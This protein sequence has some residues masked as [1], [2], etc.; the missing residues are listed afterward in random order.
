MSSDGAGSSIGQGNWSEASTTR[1]ALVGDSTLDNVLWVSGAGSQ[2]ISQQV[3][4]AVGDGGAVMNLAADGYTSGDTLHGNQRVISV[5]MRARLGDPIRFDEDGI[6]R[7]LNQIK[8]LDPPPTHIVVS[9]GGNDVR[10]IL[11][12][13]GKIGAIV[14]GF[15]ENYP[16]IVDAC[17]E[18]TPN[19]ILMLQYRPS[20]HMDGGGYG[21]Y[22]AINTMPGEGS[23]V[24]KLNRLMETIYRPVFRLAQEKGLSLI[25]LPR[26]FDLYDDSLYTHQIEPSEKG[27]AKIASMVAHVV[28]N[29]VAESGSAFYLMDKEGQMTSEGN[30]GHEWIIPHEASEKPE[31]VSDLSELEQKVMA[32]VGMGFDRKTATEALEAHQGDLQNAVN[33]LFDGS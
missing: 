18:V 8:K 9:V 23:S 31:S 5:G 33:A 4:T 19:V 20:F 24:Q 25:D 7:P 17:L 14:A 10:E 2:S 27:G 11:G 26:T 13:M 16:K 3:T 28:A 30:D 32:M 21:V 1:I 15:A 6:F 12:D 22:Q 29:H